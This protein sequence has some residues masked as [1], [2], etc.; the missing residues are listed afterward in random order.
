MK[1]FLPILFIFT[2]VLSFLPFHSVHALAGGLINSKPLI[3]SPDGKFLDLGTTTQ[4]TDSLEETNISLNRDGLND[5]YFN[6][7]YYKFSESQTINSFSIKTNTSTNNFVVK[8]YGIDKNL[9]F[10]KNLGISEW[11]VYFEDVSGVYYVEI[12]NRS[13]SNAYT[14]SEF[15]VFSDRENPFS[16]FLDGKQLSAIGSVSTLSA[17]TDNIS[18]SP[19]TRIEAKAVSGV[20][21]VYYDF[22]EPV[23]INK[24]ISR[25]HSSDMNIEF[26]AGENLLGVT[27]PLN[28]TLTSYILTPVSYENVTKIKIMN[29]SSSILMINELEF[30]GGFTPPDSESPSSIENL[31]YVSTSNSISFDWSDSSESDFSHYELRLDGLLINNTLSDSAY[32]LDDLEPDTDY[33]FEVVSVDV[34]GNKSPMKSILAKT[35]MQDNI[36]PDNLLEVQ[37]TVTENAVSFGFKLPTDE[38]FS[39]LEVYKGT[40]L[41]KSDLTAEAFSDT[42]L[43]P[44]TLYT[45]K[46]VSVDKN[47]NK[48]SGTIVNVTTKKVIDETPPE[49][50][51]NVVVEPGNGYLH[52]S[53]DASTSPDLDGYDVYI[54]GVKHNG[55]LIR[56]TFYIAK[57]LTNDREYQVQVV[58]VDK[59]GNMS[60]ITNPVVNT[61]DS[62]KLPIIE[63]EYDLGAVGSG[64]SSWFSSIWLLLAFC[65]AIPLSFLIARRVKHLFLA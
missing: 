56:N 21:G 22:P 55:S 25:S 49:Q 9:L 57:P 34:S 62:S 8:F 18:S 40:T 29:D 28:T 52:I 48:S 6:G 23:N 65:I 47:G 60:E 50:V 16:G 19:T 51:E 43:Q 11:D 42:G 45:Y 44:D 26:Y 27:K 59:S 61:P 17:M 10:T 12:Y 54:D 4:L 1:K 53:W 20:S 36:P 3:L 41:I 58:A 37:H 5:T 38:D 24:I 46:F 14:L 13:T 64:I 7:A 15:D 39:H 33:L 2:L 63:S 31:S 32:I 30:K 35:L